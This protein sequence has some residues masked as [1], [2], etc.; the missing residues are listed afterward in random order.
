[1]LHPVLQ[2]GDDGARADKRP[3]PRLDIF[4]LVALHSEQNPP[5]G[6][7]FL[8]RRQA[9]GWRLD[10][11]RG[12]LDSKFLKRLPDAQIDLVS[13]KGAEPRAVNASY[14]PNTQHR[15]S[16]HLVISFD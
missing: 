2:Y 9:M 16:A 1:M 3:E 4:D 6:F 5:D 8:G 15:N 12:R 14:R 11:P 10:N 13:F 7:R